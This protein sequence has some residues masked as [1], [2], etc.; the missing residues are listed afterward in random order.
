MK[1]LK[2]YGRLYK[3]F[4]TQFIKSLMQSK[5]DFI[6]GLLGFFLS[7][8]SGI[9]FLMLVFKQIPDLHGYSFNQLIFIYG[10]AQIPRGIDHLLTD[11]IWMLAMRLVVRGDFDRFLLR[12]INLFFQLICDRFQADAIGELIVGFALVIISISNGTV[13]IT[14]VN[15]ILFFV[16][17]IAGTVIYTS[18]K[19]IFASLAFWIKDSIGILQMGYNF[20]D[21]AKY[22]ISI[23]AKP[24][25]I[26]LTWIIPFAFVAFYPASFF[27]AKMNAIYSIGIEVLIAIIAWIISYGVFQRGTNVYESTGN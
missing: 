19:L 8:A 6:I 13:H 27:L 23:Y 18:I 25:R 15:I 9:V 21:F 2:R 5:V 7:Q 20:S 4:A 12:P 16:S 10:F 1:H 17:M 24:I 11:N 3:V 26:L 22:P 14:P